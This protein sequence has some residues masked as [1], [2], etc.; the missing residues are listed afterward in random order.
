[1]G[2]EGGAGPARFRR[3]TGADDMEALAIERAGGRT[4]RWLASD[5]NF[6]ALQRMLLLKFELKE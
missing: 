4:I 6:S 3:A 1:M 5:D 2:G